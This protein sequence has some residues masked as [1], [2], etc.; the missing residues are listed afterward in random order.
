MEKLNLMLIGKVKI[1][2]IIV[3]RNVR[4]RYVQMLSKNNNKYNQSR[5]NLCHVLMYLPVND[6][7]LYQIL[8]FEQ[9]D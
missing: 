1:I 6:Y 5:N 7:Y 8:H 9:I 3:P 4:V 2:S